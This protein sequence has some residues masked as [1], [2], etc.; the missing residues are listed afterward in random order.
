MTSIQQKKE[1]YRLSPEIIDRISQKCSQ[2]LQE[3]QADRKDAIRLRL[4]LE[5]ILSLWMDR[6][7][8]GAE[9]S[10][11][12]GTWFGKTRL[13][14]RIRGI[15]LD[16][17]SLE[18]E[19]DTGF[20]H[21]KLMAQAGSAFTYAYKNGENCLSLSL[22]KKKK[23]SQGAQLLL[24]IALGLLLGGVSLVLP[25]RGKEFL[26]SVT[27]P[28]F[29]AFLGILRAVSSPMILL[30]VCCGILSLGDV[31]TVGKVGKKVVSNLLLISLGVGVVSL[32]AVFWFFP[33]RAGGGEGTGGFQGIY[34]ML[35]DILP[36]DLISPFLDANAMQIIFMGIVLG[37]TLLI[38][39]ERASLVKKTVE[40]LNETAKLIMEGIGR[41]LPLFIFLS[42]FSLLSSGTLGNAGGILK[43]LLLCL[44]LSL[45]SAVIFTLFLS[46]RLQVSWIRLLRLLSP[47][48][49]IA[50]STASSSAALSSNLEIC[51]R[52]LGIPA[53]ITNFAVPL[54]QVLFMPT[55]VIEYLVL[56]LC[57]AETYEIAMAPS[58]LITAVFASVL[59]A[60]ASPPVPGCGLTCITVLFAQLGIPAEA[61]AAAVAVDAILDFV[62]TAI[63]LLSLQT[64]LTLTADGLGM[65]EGE[66][67]AISQEKYSSR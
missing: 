30:A 22:A 26:T 55:S 3:A 60:V 16:P 17:S 10:I 40:Q 29:Q 48:F 41:L 20:I 49:L 42:I 4:S 52:G 65:L 15:E 28:L 47:C 14:V 45:V 12:W 57:M 34:Q 11:R 25:E 51:E 63:N 37:I 58:W 1:S 35:L 38:L 64:V 7:G 44:I 8:E 9:C 61:A 62:N 39:G 23:I 56:A 53:K 24:A 50:L 27:E 18:Q 36:G 19:E 13:E 43:A 32:A 21:E 54:G 66:R 2:V 5:E 46:V 59:L 6:L 33:V 31:S 67:A